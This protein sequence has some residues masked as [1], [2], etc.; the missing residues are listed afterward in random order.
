MLD[1]IILLWYCI[2][3]T[4]R[5]QK[6]GGTHMYTLRATVLVA[7]DQKRIETQKGIETCKDLGLD[8]THWY[9]TVAKLAEAIKIIE[10]N[11]NIFRNK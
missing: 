10:N 1:S 8:P 6:K 11:P 5:T 3:V 4:E 2:V 7:L 9:E